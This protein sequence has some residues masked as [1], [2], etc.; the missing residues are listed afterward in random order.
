MFSEYLT[1]GNMSAVS[2]AANATLASSVPRSVDD[3]IAD[4]LTYCNTQQEKATTGGQ[5]NNKNDDQSTST[6]PVVVAV[7]GAPLPLPDVVATQHRVQFSIRGCRYE[8]TMDTALAYCLSFYVFFHW[9]FEGGKTVGDVAVAEKAQTSTNALTEEALLDHYV[10][11]VEPALLAFSQLQEQQCKAAST[12]VHSSLQENDDCVASTSAAAATAAAVTGVVLPPLPRPQ[13]IS[14]DALGH[15]WKFVFP[16]RLTP[17]AE[18]QERRRR[19][20]KSASNAAGGTAEEHVTSDAINASSF[21]LLQNEF[22][23]VLLVYL[24]RCAKARAEGKTTAADY[25]VLPIRWKEMNYDEQMSFVQLLRTFGVVSLAGQYVRPT[26]ALS[27]SQCVG[28]DAARVAAD[29]KAE[30][31]V[32]LQQQQQQQSGSAM[33]AT[34]SQTTDK[35][36]KKSCEDDFDDV[37]LPAEGCARCGISGHAMEECPY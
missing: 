35:P 12:E 18:A 36:P 30:A 22:M 2:A 29:A 31:L 34:E 37:V 25:P 27:S 13:C 10:K 20:R 26:A 19:G 7:V 33:Q 1:S 32:R 6:T 9:P 3:V 4:L 21:L 5:S 17:E 23:G 24:R 16:P 11:Y 15:V 8:T 14:Y 28:A